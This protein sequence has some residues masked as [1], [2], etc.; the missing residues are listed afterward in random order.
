MIL[1]DNDRNFTRGSHWSIKNDTFHEFTV[2][3]YF[4]ARMPLHEK[5]NYC[6]YL[7]Y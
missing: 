5:I 1:K 6:C 2:C 7:I 3:P 4:N